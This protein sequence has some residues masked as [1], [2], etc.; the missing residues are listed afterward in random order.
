VSL[1]AR[2]GRYRPERAIPS[3]SHWRRI[4]IARD[5]GSAE[6]DGEE[7][8]QRRGLGIHLRWLRALLDLYQPKISAYRSPALPYVPHR[9]PRQ[10]GQEISG[11][12]RDGCN[13]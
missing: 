1:T 3:S 11:L 2:R 9:D 7:E 12:H 5:V 13:Q 4:E 6:R 8:A 10:Y